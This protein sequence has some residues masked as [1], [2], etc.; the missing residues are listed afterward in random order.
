M[1]VRAIGSNKIF[2]FLCVIFVFQKRELRMSQRKDKGVES[3]DSSVPAETP[4]EL[5]MRLLRQTVADMNRNMQDMRSEQE[6]T[7]RF[8]HEQT[9]S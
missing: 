1:R 4:M 2:F 7:A 3:T 8:I 6:N 5:E 9:A